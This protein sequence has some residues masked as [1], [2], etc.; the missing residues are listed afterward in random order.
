[1]LFAGGEDM[2]LGCWGRKEEDISYA[3]LERGMELVVWEL[4]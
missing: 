2:V 3:D 1:M 4:R